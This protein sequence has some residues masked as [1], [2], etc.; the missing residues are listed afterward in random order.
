MIWI[1]TKQ[2]LLIFLE[3]LKKNMSKPTK[4][5]HRGYFRS[6]WTAVY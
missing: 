1:G 6:V 3:K 5:N 2:E 4:S